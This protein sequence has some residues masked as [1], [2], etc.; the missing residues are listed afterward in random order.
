M[1]FKNQ[2]I[3]KVITAAILIALISTPLLMPKKMEAAGWPVIDAIGNALK[4]LILVKETTQTAIATKNVLKEVLKQ[5]ARAAAKRLLAELTKS[6]VNWI[7][8]G[9]HGSP[10]FLEDPDSFFEDIT[11]REIRTLVDIFGYT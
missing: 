9:F 4:S 11:K 1:I 2:K 8:S 6:T 5:V 7:N 3:K 10:L